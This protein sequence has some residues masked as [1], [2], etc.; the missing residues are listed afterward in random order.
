MV[1]GLQYTKL[2]KQFSTLGCLGIVLYSSALL[3]AASVEKKEEVRA[4]SQPHSIQQDAQVEQTGCTDSCCGAPSCSTSCCKAVC[5]PKKVTEEVKKHCWCVKAKQICIPKWQFS[6]N[7]GTCNKKNVDCGD[8]C[9]SG[10]CCDCPPPACGRVR[11]INVLEKHEYKCE[12]CGYEWEVKC[13]R[14]GRK[15]CSCDGCSCPSCG[16]HCDE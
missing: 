2:A 4:L 5:C 7:F 1:N 16:H 15:T 9:S 12:E 10:T 6:L 11:C 8:C 3:S 14:A 13:V